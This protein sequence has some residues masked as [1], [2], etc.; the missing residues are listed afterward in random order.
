MNK[1]IGVIQ[2]NFLHLRQ[3]GQIEEAADFDEI[4]EYTD[5]VT[6][7]VLKSVKEG[8]FDSKNVN[9]FTMPNLMAIEDSFLF[10]KDILPELWD[11][12]ISSRRYQEQ[13]LDQFNEES[14]LQTSE[15]AY[16]HLVNT[17]K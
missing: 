3:R 15:T 17:N 9:K 4:I 11:K 1:K 14:I 13:Q 2:Q 7:N 16:K 5:R 12:T 6:F 10:G 8:L